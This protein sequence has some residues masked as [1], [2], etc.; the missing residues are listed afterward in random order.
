MYAKNFGPG[1][2]WLSGNIIV[3]KKGPVTFEI[4][5]QNGKRLQQN[6]DHVRERSTS[7]QTDVS[8][9]RGDEVIDWPTAKS[10]NTQANEG[11]SPEQVETESPVTNDGGRHYQSRD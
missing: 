6:Q 2:K 4:E 9:D 10:T 11:D 1:D 7:E 8:S 5:L 3:R